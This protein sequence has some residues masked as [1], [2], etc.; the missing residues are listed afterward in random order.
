MFTEKQKYRNWLE[1]QIRDHGLISTHVC[2]AADPFGPD[3]ET[4]ELRF[5]SN[6]DEAFY[7]ALNEMNAAIARGDYTEIHDL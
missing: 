2:T 3:V 6:H 7:R 5:G 4:D 1:I